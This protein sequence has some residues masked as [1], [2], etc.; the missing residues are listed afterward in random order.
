MDNTLVGT[1]SVG[2]DLCG[3]RCIHPELVLQARAFLADEG[4]YRRLADLFAA[5]ADMTRARLVH[6]LAR[7][8]LCTCD[9]AAVVGVSES[10]V[11]QHLRV[12][13]SLRVV[14]TRRAGK[15]VFYSLDDAHLAL[16]IQVGLTHLGDESP[17]QS[18]VPSAVEERAP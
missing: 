17:A 5:L 3:V 16:L 15:F 14:K 4:T 1:L 18:M 13:R 12:L 2:N 6:T 9:L 10:A 8:E 7:Q 11:S